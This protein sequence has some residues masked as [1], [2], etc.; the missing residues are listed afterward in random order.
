MAV[1]FSPNRDQMIKEIEQCVVLGKLEM[2]QCLCNSCMYKVLGESV[3]LPQC[4]K[5]GVHHGIAKIAK[6]AKWTAVPDHEFLGV[7]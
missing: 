5:C 4:L 2:L 1:N 7:C 3:L 6:A